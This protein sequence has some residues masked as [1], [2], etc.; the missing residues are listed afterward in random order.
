MRRHNSGSETVRPHR[1]A[2]DSS[3]RGVS[4]RG[5][6]GLVN[7]PAPRIARLALGCS[8]RVSQTGGS[9]ASSSSSGRTLKN[10]LL[11]LADAMM[12]RLHG[13]AMMRFQA[14]K[15]THVTTETK[16]TWQYGDLPENQDSTAEAR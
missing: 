7:F 11:F 10:L 9:A 1:V 12:R 4:L 5:R 6:Q 3:G 2:R 13:T 8:N 16:R 14:G 15:V